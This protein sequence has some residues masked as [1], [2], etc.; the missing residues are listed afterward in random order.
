M[1]MH[2][3]SGLDE[4]KAHGTDGREVGRSG[5]VNEM[6]HQVAVSADALDGGQALRLPVELAMVGHSEVLVLLHHLR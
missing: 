5:W 1:P 3:G 6:G 4:A 2:I